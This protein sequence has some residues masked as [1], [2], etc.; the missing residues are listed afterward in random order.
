MVTYNNKPFKL[1]I[2]IPFMNSALWLSHETGKYLDDL[3][4]CNEKVEGVLLYCRWGNQHE[5]CV[6]EDPFVLGIGNESEIGQ[7]PEAE[8]V[9]GRL[10]ATKKEYRPALFLTHPRW[11]VSQYGQDYL[12]KPSQKDLE[13][14]A[15]RMPYF[16]DAQMMSLIVTPETKLIDGRDHPELKYLKFESPNHRN[17]VDMLRRTIEQ[18]KKELDI[19]IPYP[20]LTV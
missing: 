20:P 11:A 17:R 8:I 16:K 13:R 5:N 19:T 6:V 10:L 7:I 3:T 1:K 9:L 15:S 2:P 4:R 18:I 14:I 12:K